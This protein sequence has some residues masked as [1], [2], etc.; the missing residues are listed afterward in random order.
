[1]K[2]LNMA[3]CADRHD[4]PQATDG[5][6]FRKI[7]NITDIYHLESLAFQ[8]LWSQCRLK[9]WLKYASSIFPD[10]DNTE[11][12][13]WLA[14]PPNKIHLNLYVT[15]LTPALIAA[16]NVCKD[17]KIGVTLYHYDRSTNGYFTQEVR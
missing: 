8:S 13:D 14:I 3:L 5:Y 9:E 4:I 10:L 7:E 6:I 12:E 2:V 16:L 17:E 15:G 1:M 11:K